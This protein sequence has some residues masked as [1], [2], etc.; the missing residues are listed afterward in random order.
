LDGKIKIER[1]VKQNGK[2]KESC[3]KE[4]ESCKKEKIVTD[5]S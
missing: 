2:E 5:F 1:K 4:K 3:K